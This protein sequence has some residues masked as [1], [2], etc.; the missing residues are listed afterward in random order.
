MHLFMSEIFIFSKLCSHVILKQRCC[1]KERSEWKIVLKN[2]CFF[3][4]KRKVFFI[5]IAFVLKFIELFNWGEG[6][7]ESRRTNS[8]GYEHEKS[9]KNW[10]NISVQLFKNLLKFWKI[11]NFEIFDGEEGLSEK[12][13]FVDDTKGSSNFWF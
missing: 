2:V 12:N 13:S 6:G 3:P 7:L 5:F 4:S 11:D 8:F 10:C 9:S 1:G